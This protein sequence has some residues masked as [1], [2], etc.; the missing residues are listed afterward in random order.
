MK[1]S[2]AGRLKSD[3]NTYTDSTGYQVTG[4]FMTGIEMNIPKYLMELMINDVK[5]ASFDA[6]A[7]IYTSQTPFYQ[8]ALSEFISDEKDRAEA[9]TQLQS[10][11]VNL[12]KKDNKF[13]F[14][15]GRHP[16]KWHDEYQSFITL[17]DRIPVISIGEVSISK[18]LT[19]LA[20]YKMP[21]N[22]DD[23]FY[24]YIKA[25]PDLWY[26]FG[27]Q[28]TEGSAVLNVVSSS[29]RFNDVLAGMKAKDLQV[30]MPNGELY[31]VV[32]ANPSVA[33]AFLNRVRSGR[34]N[35]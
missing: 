30:K 28:P 29:V 31:E 32:P 3:Y 23:R 11:L 9:M 8:A 27:Y 22:Q 33:E 5:A 17:E 21:T 18:M 16:V 13:A 24:L 25:S 10:N 1:V 35:N 14:V 6:P 19:V 4:E 12:P 34:T 7:I 26:F 2:G 20:E 15:L